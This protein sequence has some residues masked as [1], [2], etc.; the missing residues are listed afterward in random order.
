[1]V[2][3]EKQLIDNLGA[4]DIELSAEE[5]KQLDEVSAIK[6]EYPQYFPPFQ[7]G[8]NLFSRFQNE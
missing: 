1:M 2:I 7:R 3:T 4:V 6:M 8:E 5:V